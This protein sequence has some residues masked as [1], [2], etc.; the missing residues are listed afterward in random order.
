MAVFNVKATV[1][2]PEE[3]NIPLVRADL[4]AV[5]NLFRVFFE[6]FLSFFSATL[7]AV[8]TMG[9][10][11]TTFHLVVLWTCGGCVLAFGGCAFYHG[12]PSKHG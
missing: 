10:A 6:L 12:R 9:D 2:A 8:M 7:G 5:G 3:I 1:S 4:H 11:A